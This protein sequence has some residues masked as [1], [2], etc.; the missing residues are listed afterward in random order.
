MRRDLLSRT[1][2][3]SR[4]TLIVSITAVSIGDLIGFV[5]GIAS[6]CLGQR[7]DLISQRVVDVLMSFPDLILALLLPVVLGAGLLTVNVAISVTPHPLGHAHHPCGG[8]FNQGDLLRRGRPHGR[9]VQYVRM[10]VRHVAPQ[11]VAPSLV[12]ATSAGFD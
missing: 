11:A 7:F 12:V 9:R 2:F 3:G 1:V 8:A 5:C 4:I 6:G 10:M